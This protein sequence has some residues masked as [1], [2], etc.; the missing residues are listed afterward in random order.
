LALAV[1]GE[2][3]RT[4]RQEITVREQRLEALQVER[5][6]YTTPIELDELTERRMRKAV[7]EQVKQ[8]R[9]LLH[10]NVA[11][12]RQVLRKLLHGPIHFVPEVREG[13]KTFRFYGETKLG[14][15]LDPTFMKMASPRGFVSHASG[16]LIPFRVL[17]KAA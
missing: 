11:V 10:D 15:L 14:P 6:S 4:I 13:R 3:P 9:D 8:Y 7:R 1:E 5:D 2:A 12:A 16:L 17:K